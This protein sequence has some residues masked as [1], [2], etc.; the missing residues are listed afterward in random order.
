MVSYQRWTSI[1]FEV[2]QSKGMQST[3]K[4][5][6]ELISFAADLWRREKPTLNAATVAE[7]TN[8]AQNQIV[9]R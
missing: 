1:C 6:R 2:A 9:I 7:A 5:N 8:I 3:Q 4:N